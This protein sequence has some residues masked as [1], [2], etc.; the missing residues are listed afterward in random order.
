METCPV[1]EG[2]KTVTGIGCNMDTGCRPITI[3]CVLCDGKGLVTI[4]QADRYRE[5]HGWR[6][7]R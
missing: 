7:Y 4:E 5:E 3:D 6:K 1:C 2:S